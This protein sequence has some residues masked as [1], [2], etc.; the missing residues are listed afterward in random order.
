MSHLKSQN[1]DTCLSLINEFHDSVAVEEADTD[2]MLKK[3]EA[4]KA[5]SHLEMFLKG[6]FSGPGHEEQVTCGAEQK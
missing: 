2:L 1:V 5:L 6:N 4:G 3:Q